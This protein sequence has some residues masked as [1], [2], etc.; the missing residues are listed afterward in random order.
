M[1]PPLPESALRGLY[2]TDQLIE[3]GK[4]CAAAEQDR[5]LRIVHEQAN[6]Y[7]KAGECMA[8]GIR[9]KVRSKPDVGIRT[10]ETKTDWSAA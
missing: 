3:H 4:A 5:I 8:I 7:G 1:M 6:T 2:S 10:S 9:A